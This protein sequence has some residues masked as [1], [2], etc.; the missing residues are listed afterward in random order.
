MFGCEFVIVTWPISLEA[1]INN[2]FKKQNQTFH[3]KGTQNLKYMV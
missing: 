2:K 1:N 3:C